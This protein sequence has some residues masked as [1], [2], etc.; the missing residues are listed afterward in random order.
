MEN[1]KLL[2]RLFLTMLFLGALYTLTKSTT[3][4]LAKDVEVKDVEVEC[5]THNDPPA[6]VA[7]IV[8][9]KKETSYKPKKQVI[10][11]SDKK[12]MGRFKLTGYCACMYCCGKTDG[13]T[14]TGVKAKAGRTIA[15]DPRVIPYGSIVIINGKEYVAEDC[16]GAIK[17]KK[18]DIFFNTH[19]EALEWGVKY[20]EVYVKVGD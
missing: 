1:K 17:N 12:Y 6:G 13:I 19:N 4:T 11:T 16:G 9:V 8:K 18:I 15:V 14:S 10:K 5:V 20:A 3:F 2:I 7:N